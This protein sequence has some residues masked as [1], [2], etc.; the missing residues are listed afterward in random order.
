MSLP[1]DRG[2]IATEQV[3]GG[4]VSLD[5]LSTRE[6]VDLLSSDHEQAIN[7]VQ[8]A[9]ASISAFIDDVHKKILKGGRLIYIG[10]GTSGRLG[11]LDA[12]ECPPTFQS[13]PELI[14]GLIAGGDASLR[15]SSEAKEDD[16][17]GIIPEFDR[18]GISNSDTVLGIAAGGT[19]PWVIGGLRAA[20][21]RGAMTGFITCS[22]IIEPLADHMI[23][24]DTGPEPLTGSTRLKAGTATKLTLNIISTTLFTQLGKVY[25]NLMV[26]LKATNNKLR[27]RAIRIITSICGTEREESAAIL[28][29]AHGELKTAIVMHQCDLDFKS[30]TQKLEAVGGNLRSAL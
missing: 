6:C 7:A 23:F 14:V 18:L 4:T 16:P 17:L 9:N 28:E 30:A 22:S 25:G 20:T 13:D 3:H 5:M 11:V 1:P 21:Q 8:K 24:L 26:D 27:D 12:A 15:T 29:N 19:T 2:H 10:C